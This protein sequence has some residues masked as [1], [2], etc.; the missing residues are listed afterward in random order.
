MHPLCVLIPLL[1]LCGLPQPSL[2]PLK[3]TLSPPS[4][5]RPF[6]R[7]PPP[8]APHLAQQLKDTLFAMVPAKQKE[9]KEFNAANGEKSLGNVTVGQAIGGARDVKCMYW[10]TSLLDAQE[11][12]CCC[13]C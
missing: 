1:K 4:P 12:R 2:A 11:V 5:S 9:L 8:L 3:L 6:H 10:E 13:C 7:S